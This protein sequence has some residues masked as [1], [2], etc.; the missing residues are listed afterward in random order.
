MTAA[1]RHATAL[2]R[3]A[4]SLTGVT[5]LGH[6]LLGFEQAYLAP[7]V[8]VVT[9]MTAEFV[10]ETVE[11]WARGRPARYLD[12]RP[13]R[14]V[15]FFL[16]SYADGLLCAMLLY[17]E[18]HLAPV[19]LATLVGVGGRYA[20]RVRV[21]G[22]PRPRTRTRTRTWA[23]TRA[24]TRARTWARP[25]TP[26]GTPPEEF[27]GSGPQERDAPGRP[28]LNPVASGVTAVLLLFPWVGMAPPY[29][30][31]AWVSG[32]FDVIVPLAVLV[33]GVRAH[34]LTGRLPL[35]LGWVGGFVLQGLARSALGDVSVAGAL[36]PMT[37]TAFVLHTCYVLPDPGTT[38]F[39]PR[40]QIA[41]GLAAAA[42]YGLL[43]HFPVAFGP[44]LS[45]VV[46]C[47]CR[48]A[49]L[50]LSARVRPPA[51]PAAVTV[52]APSPAPDPVFALAL[53]EE[54]EDARPWL[55]VNT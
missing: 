39:R 10:L 1:H 49:F 46:V 26:P 47:L 31:T 52:P 44:S 15:E 55:R 22:V 48:G 9:G 35:V 40:N 6:C 32:P 16:P 21:P 24:R 7:L 12:R 20:L 17:G 42:G 50:A 5:V 27:P 45:L 51:V 43:V 30:F 4:G 33:L 54:A 28:Y 2:R 3:L 13:G 18:A 37:G 8:G 11:A 34:R 53:P 14:A 41:F 25:G 38:P 36:L 19:A 29:Q 23:R